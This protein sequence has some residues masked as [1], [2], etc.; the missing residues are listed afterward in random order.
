MADPLSLAASIAGIISLT[1]TVFR[2][3]FRYSRTA[4]GAKE[5]VQQLSEEINSFAGVL[6]SLHALA[7]HFEAEGQE[8]KSALRVEHLSQCERTFEKIERKVK[9]AADKFNSSR[10]QGLAQQMKWPYSVSETKELLAD[11]SRYKDTISLAASADNMKQLQLLL[12]KQAENHEKTEKT[13]MKT[14]EKV[15]ISTQILLDNQKKLVL[16]FFMKPEGNPQRNLDQSIKWRQPTTGTWLL[17]SDELKQWFTEPGSRLWLKGIP[18]GGKTILAGAVIQEALTRSSTSNSSLGVAFYFCDYKDE[19]T[20]APIQILGAI[21]YQLALQRDDAFELL[22]AYYQELHPQ[23]ALS[24]SPDVDELRAT[25][26]RM[27]ETFDESFIIIDGVDECAEEVD[28]VARAL[29]ELADSADTTSIAVFS[30]DEEE[31][32][33]ELEDDFTE[34]IIAARTEDIETYIRAEMKLRESRGQLLV[35]DAS[36]KEKI[37]SELVTR[38]RGMFRWVAC[39]LDYLS[40]LWTDSDRLEALDDLPHTLHDSYLRILRKLS[41]LPGKTQDMVRLCLRILAFF[42]EPLTIKELCQAVSTPEKLGA[43]IE[44]IVDETFIARKCSSLIRKSADGEHFEFAH[45]TVQEFLADEALLKLSEFAP[46]RIS[47]S[48]DQPVIGLLCLKFV[49]LQ[50]FEIQSSETSELFKTMSDTDPDSFYHAAAMEWPRL[51]ADGLNSPDLLDAA[52][53]LFRPVVNGKYYLWAFKFISMMTFWTTRAVN[54]P[55][56]NSI[57]GPTRNGKDGLIASLHP[58]H[59]A[60]ALNLPEICS[61]LIERGVN[62]SICSYL[63]TPLELSQASF[64]LLHQWYSFK[65]GDFELPSL[66]SR[67]LKLASPSAERRDATLT[68]LLEAGATFWTTPLRG[69]FLYSMIISWSLQDFSSTITLVSSSYV[70]P[71]D[72]VERF[73][74]YIDTWWNPRQDSSRMG[75]ALEAFNDYLQRSSAFGSSWGFKLGKIIWSAAVSMELPFTKDPSRTDS[76]ISLSSEALKTQ[77]VFAITEDNS[78]A[79]ITYLDDGRVG[80]SEI[81]CS[82]E[83]PSEPLLLVAVR[84]NAAKCVSLLLDKGADPYLRNKAGGNS[85]LIAGALWS[86]DVLDVFVRHGLSLL[87]TDTDGRTLWHIAASSLAL[88]AQFLNILFTSN[89]EETQKGLSMKTKDGKTPLAIALS[90]RIEPKNTFAKRE[91]GLLVFINHC[92]NVPGFWETQEPIFPAAFDTSSKLVVQRLLELR[93]GPMTPGVADA[94]PLHRLN[95]QASWD[96]VEYLKSLFPDATESRYQGILPIELY[97]DTCLRAGEGPDDETLDRLAFDGLFKCQD[98]RGLD[99]WSFLCI[100]DDR[101]DSYVLWDNWHSF[102]VASAYFLT[103]GCIEAYEDTKA[104][105]VLEPFMSLLELWLDKKT[106]PPDV[107]DT[108]LLNQ[109]ITTSQHWDPKSPVSTQFLR[110]AICNCRH[111]IVEALLEHGLD[112]HHYVDEETTIEFACKQACEKHDRPGWRDTLKLL[113]AHCDPEKMNSFSYLGYGLLHHLADPS[114]EETGARWMISELIAL[115]VDI[116]GVDEKQPAFGRKTPL[117]HHINRHSFI[118]AEILL[119]KGA[120]PNGENASDGK[121]ETRVLHKGTRRDLIPYSREGSAPISVVG[122]CLRPVHA[123]AVRGNI[124]LLRKMLQ[125]SRETNV[126]IDWEALFSISPDIGRIPVLSRGT[127]LTSFHMACYNGSLEVFNFFVEEVPVDI[128]SKASAGLTPLHLAALGGHETIINRLVQCGRE[129]MVFDDDDYTPLHFAA[130]CGHTAATRALIRLGVRD[131]I[132]KLGQ[133]AHEVATDH[134]ENELANILKTELPIA[135]ISAQKRHTSEAE[136]PGTK[137]SEQNFGVSVSSANSLLAQLKSAIEQ[138]SLLDCQD[139]RVRG[140]PLNGVIAGTNGLSPLIYSMQYNRLDITRWI[141][142]Q[143]VSTMQYCYQDGVSPISALDFAL[144]HENLA[145]I[146]PFLLRT[147]AEQGGDWNEVA[148]HSLREA[149]EKS[150]NSGLGTLVVYLDGLSSSNGPYQKILSQI[151]AQPFGT[152]E[153]NDKFEYTAP[154]LHHAVTRDNVRAAR[155]LLA[156]EAPIDTIDSNGES[157]L[158]WVRSREM[159]EL[160]VEYG[161]SVTPLL[162]ESVPTLLDRWGRS[163]VDIV[164]TLAR[165]VTKQEN[166]APLTWLDWSPPAFLHQ[167]ED[168]ETTIGSLMKLKSLGSS[169]DHT[170]KADSYLFGTE[171][172]HGLEYILNSDVELGDMEPFPWHLYGAIPFARMTFL[173]SHFHHVCRRF[174]PETLARFANLNPKKGWSPLCRAASQNATDKMENC[175]SLGADTEFE[176]CPLG[177]ALMI[178]SACGQLDAVKLLIRKGAK[179]NY[180]GRHGF[181]NVLSVARSRSVWSWLLVGRFNDQPR[182]KEAAHNEPPSE[183]KPWSGFYQAKHNMHGFEYIRDKEAR[184]DY[185]KRLVRYKRKMRS[186]VAH[187][188]EGLI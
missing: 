146:L 125:I 166:L 68:C 151:L 38:A 144:D 67:L 134:R 120:N 35:K 161:A 109:V 132:T 71:E 175:L 103:H 14:L 22:E 55:Y 139:L 121:G 87:T 142:F 187:Y 133:N 98:D 29:V 39:Q 163:S 50:N 101:I 136:L 21:A 157:P 81:G 106:W 181:L 80:A 152:R 63:D 51:T 5:E 159:A 173:G 37:E 57:L 11:I 94:K 34:I 62:V 180:T 25:I 1:D 167:L 66:E 36:V 70:P 183:T 42:P 105:C 88:E 154:I 158:A 32:R 23:R 135:E 107:F 130:R 59:M 52:K 149:I 119:D 84:R 140:C 126:N 12:S 148:I 27:V 83:S 91:K 185:A 145:G 172:G 47:R 129:V 97:V 58:L 127:C 24:Q 92:N 182:I 177:S 73:G 76:R 117:A 124:S 26:T 54:A 150:N 141:L 184:I 89:I 65:H 116:N 19:K 122:L 112:V 13:L 174:G 78:Q 137:I 28:D 15:E 108:K 123:C 79:L 6:R 179:V 170:W 75:V 45:F 115:G 186:R 147:F 60:A 160:L 30:R 155:L 162:T 10:L 86:W 153:E 102:K 93:D 143:G 128:Q 138:G 46:Y 74:A 99:P 9:K 77:V 118:C 85:I 20:H 56:D 178:A 110:G 156:H 168:S 90:A 44:N 3:A 8:F 72:E 176:G 2:Y 82:R 31:I 113:F 169:S 64:L 49:Q 40:E 4:L 164:E 100:A 41:K 7:C 165:T 104:E 111:E 16:D 43:R 33:A 96:W 171:H 48:L 18:G 95:S 114:W 17:E 69:L 53:S 131:S 61:F 188:I